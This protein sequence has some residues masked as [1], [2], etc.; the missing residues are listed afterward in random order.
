MLSQ[1]TP[2]RQNPR[3]PELN[4]RVT[5]YEYGKVVDAALALGHGQVCLVAAGDRDMSWLEAY[6]CHRLGEVR[7]G[8]QE[9]IACGS[10]T[11]FVV[12]KLET[13]RAQ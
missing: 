4:R 10:G 2:Y 9:T 1:Y 12:Y 5:S 11:E 8:V 3:Y 13:A 7:L 6:L